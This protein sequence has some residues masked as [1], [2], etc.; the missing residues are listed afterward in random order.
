MM[1]IRARAASPP[2]TGIGELDG[3]GAGAG[4][5]APKRYNSVKYPE[6]PVRIDAIS[7]HGPFRD[8]LRPGRIR[9]DDMRRYSF[10]RFYYEKV[11]L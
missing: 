1:T 2:E 10:E 5:F 4:E 7:R 8:R 3:H 11:A 6:P 9:E